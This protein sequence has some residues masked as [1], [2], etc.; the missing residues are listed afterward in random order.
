MMRLSLVLLRSAVLFMGL[1]LSFTLTAQSD[2]DKPSADLLTPYDAMYTHLYYLQKEHYDPSMA[3]RPFYKTGEAAQDLAIKLKQ[4][5]DGK[6]LQVALSLVPENPD[7]QDT[8]TNKHVYIP[9]PERFPEI[10]LNRNKV[11]K[12]WRF[13]RETERAIPDLHKQVYPF[14]SDRLLILLPGMGHQK[15]LGLALWQY[16]GV[17]ILGALAFLVYFVSSRI[18]GLVIR[19]VAN[20]R[21]G[22][23][24]FDR[25]LV[26]KIAGVL[27]S[28]FVVYLLYMFFPVLQFPI[29]LAFYVLLILKLTTTFLVVMLAL[30]VVAFFRSYLEMLTSRTKT[31]TDEHLL[32][33]VIRIVNVVII[34]AGVI[35]A[36]SIF[37]VNVNALLAG[38]SL[39]GLA[40]AL[41]AQETLRNLLGSMM[42]Y[43]DRPFQ[44]GD[45]VDVGG[46]TGTVVDIGFRSTRI[47]TPDT[48]IISVPNGNLMN[49]T[50]NNLGERELRR[51][52]TTIGVAY[53]TPPD[54]IE[55]FVKGL[56]ELVQNY[57]NTSSNTYYVYLNNMNASSI[58]IM[59]II[60]FKTNEW[61]VELEWKQE[62][63]FSILRMAEALGVQIAF[64]ST[65]VYIETQP[66][67]KPMVP[68]YQQ[69]LKEAESRLE[70]FMDEF[71]KKYQTDDT[72]SDTTDIGPEQ[73]NEELG[74]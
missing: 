50:I 22:R 74:K 71:I 69:E 53:H 64:P 41:A 40:V 35:N 5:L 19:V 10:Y 55:T 3:A 8:L 42:L 43:A 65:S 30:R 57:P 38:L 62:I 20:S 73:S 16:L 1:L 12:K 14:G 58:D 7:Y 56:R 52:S 27:S 15:F 28:L 13:S 21:L 68:E 11:T 2:E 60:Y 25:K 29:D 48:S 61:A 70:G 46:V 33:I 36:L 26:R 9:F 17:L 44:I 54:L 31:T 51:Y 37:S 67:K 23:D 59:F 66:E 49:E 18:F 32:P 63:I 45:F 47:K 6:G 24:L 72:Q 39:G 34:G 4:I